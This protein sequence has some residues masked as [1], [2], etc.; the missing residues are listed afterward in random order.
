MKNNQG[1]LSGEPADLKSFVRNLGVDGVGIADLGLL[2]GMPTGI[3]PDA[4]GFLSRYH[5][6]IVL[7]AQL[8]KLGKEASGTEVSL[9]LEKVCLVVCPRAKQYRS[10]HQGG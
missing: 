2:E 8:G 1:Q 7:G 3:A 9:Y 5:R 4:T 10:R 6:A